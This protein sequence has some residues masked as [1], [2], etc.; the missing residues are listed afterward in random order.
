MTYLDTAATA[1]RPQPVIDALARF[2]GT[3]N[4]NPRAALHTLARR[5]MDGGDIRQV[6]R[7]VAAGTSYGT[8]TYVYHLDAAGS[9]AVVCP[10]NQ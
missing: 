7:Q 6:E 4:A 1:L 3:I 10:V 9:P 8:H 5:A 2:Y